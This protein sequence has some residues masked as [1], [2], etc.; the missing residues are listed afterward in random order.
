[1]ES[2]CGNADRSKCTQLQ[3]R[4]KPL[5]SCL[6]KHPDFDLK[7]Y[8]FLTVIYVVQLPFC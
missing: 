6:I 5:F 4:T 1:M 3:G 2:I 7:K 8:R